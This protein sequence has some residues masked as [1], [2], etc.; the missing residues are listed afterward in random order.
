[1][2]TKAVKIL[3]LVFALTQSKSPSIHGRTVESKVKKESEE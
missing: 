3:R 1:M 2:G